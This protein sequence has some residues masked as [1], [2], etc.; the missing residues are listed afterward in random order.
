MHSDL[1]IIKLKSFMKLSVSAIKRLG[2][3][4]LIDN[5]RVPKPVLIYD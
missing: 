1:G 5:R 4:T 2:K 3:D